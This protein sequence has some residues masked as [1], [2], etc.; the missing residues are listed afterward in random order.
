MIEV[1]II[2]APHAFPSLLPFTA[3]RMSVAESG[4][5]WRS[6]RV[7]A[8]LGADRGVVGIQSGPRTVSTCNACERIAIFLKST[9]MSL[10][11]PGASGTGGAS[12]THS[13][14]GFKLIH[15]GLCCGSGCVAGLSVSSRQHGL[16]N[17]HTSVSESMDRSRTVEK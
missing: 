7:L 11:T 4:T 13:W 15:L 2:T 5:E 12:P 14:R 10:T 1:F 17:A 8:D 9:H 6:G 16:L 3:Y